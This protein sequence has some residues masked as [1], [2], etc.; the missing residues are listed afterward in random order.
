M[1]FSSTDTDACGAAAP[2]VATACGVGA[3]AAVAAVG[4]GIPVT[5]EADGA[6]VADGDVAL[7]LDVDG[8]PDAAAAMVATEAAQTV[9]KPTIKTRAANLALKRV[10]IPFPNRP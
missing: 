9:P 3:D 8:P 10:C 7:L 5:P 4:S 6:T 2:P 1:F